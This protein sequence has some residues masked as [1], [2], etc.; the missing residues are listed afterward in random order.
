[1]MIM[2]TRTTAMT[3]INVVV[4][5]VIL[6]RWKNICFLLIF[7]SHSYKTEIKDIY[8]WFVYKFKWMGGGILDSTGKNS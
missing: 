8:K 1:M 4:V 2:S 5:V 6:K 7:Y 3:I